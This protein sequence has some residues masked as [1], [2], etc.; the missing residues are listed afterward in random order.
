M[1]FKRFTLPL[2]VAFLLLFS[3]CESNAE[4]WGKQSVDSASEVTKKV[5]QTLDALCSKSNDWNEPSL[6]S[7]HIY[8]GALRRWLGSLQPFQQERARRI[9]RE[10]Q[11]DMSE[12]RRAIREKK[13]ELAA[14][15]YDR[16]TTPET[17]PR[18]GMELQELRATL[19]RKL[20]MLNNRLYFEAGVKLGPMGDSCYWL[21][22][23]STAPAPAQ[24][25][26]PNET[27]LPDQ[28]TKAPGA[29]TI[30]WKSDHS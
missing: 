28:L 24:P 11:P 10:S 3:A 27:Q 2:L 6:Q 5:E 7:E 17:L 30:K 19:L 4:E 1:L 20:Q 22:P 21:V 23:S 26:I 13:S 18:L 16:N 8:I 15:S 25:R 12:L 14:L 9:L 29:R